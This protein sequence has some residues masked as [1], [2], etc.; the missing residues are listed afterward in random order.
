MPSY[1]STPILAPR[2]AADSLVSPWPQAAGLRS[3]WRIR[4]EVR[5]GNLLLI[6]ALYLALTQNLSLA[7]AVA[8]SLPQPF[9]WQEWRI[10][11]SVFVTLLN[12]I[13]L[14]LIPLSA[15]RLLKPAVVLFLLVAAVCSYFMDSFGVVIDRSM[16]VNAVR[17]DTREVG[18]LLGGPFWMHLFAFGV[19]PALGVLRLRLRREPL[20][21][22]LRSRVLLA[23]AVL[24]VQGSLL[25]LQY[26]ELS[27]WG[28]NHREVRLLVNPTYPLYSAAR[29]LRSRLPSGPARPLAVIAADATRTASAADARPF[30]LV[31]VVGETARAQNFQL[32]GYARATNP[33]LSGLSDLVNFSEV[34]SC[35]TA[36]A[37]SVPCMFSGLPRRGF[38]QDRASAQQ[39]VLDVLTRV[40]IAVQW[41]DNDS[42]CQGVCVRVPTRNLEKADD[43]AHCAAGECRDGILLRDLSQ[44]GPPPGA[45]GL[46]VLHMKGSHG[47]AY[48]KRYPDSARHFTPDCRDENVQRCSREEVVN[49]YDNSLVYTDAVLADLI[50][51]LRARDDLDS[52]VIYVSDHGESLGENGLY[53]HGLPY[54]LA[55]DEQTRVPLL[56]WFSDGAR[57]TL[58]LD[59]RCL[60]RSATA[61]VSHDHLFHSLLG[62][63]SVQTGLYESGLDLFAACRSKPAAG[64]SFPSGALLTKR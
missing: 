61:P 46:L 7:H 63:F 28:R 48:F 20:W 25:G 5:A 38:S 1:S 32:N 41:W 12:L 49:A 19:L 54:A 50:Q 18:D 51:R 53:L 55:P 42:G 34:R 24:L 9:G 8:R 15:P 23:A 47:P 31:L 52:A 58:G 60:A 16:I 22:L 27:F 29:Y 57:Q 33:Q 40:G 10:A 30:L 64:A 26:N 43:P 3:L 35:G 17:T 39:N 62:L 45:S 13:V 14:A 11:A 56:A 44:A 21:T 36:T 6:V 59:G 37:E 4:P 2:G